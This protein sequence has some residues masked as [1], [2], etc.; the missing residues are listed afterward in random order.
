VLNERPRRGADRLSDVTVF[1]G[2]FI[3]EIGLELI[4]KCTLQEP[5]MSSKQSGTSKSKGARQMKITSAPPLSGRYSR[6]EGTGAGPQRKH[7]NPPPKS[8]KK[9]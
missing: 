7:A 3:P 1:D 9:K 8:G 2:F 6:S 5:L 4:A